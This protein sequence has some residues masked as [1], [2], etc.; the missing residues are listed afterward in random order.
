MH[1]QRL[2][3]GGDKRARQELEAGPELPQELEHL[4]RLYH[5]F[6]LGRSSGG[7]GS[8]EMGWVDVVCWMEATDRWLQPH[9]VVGLLRIDREVMNPPDEI[10]EDD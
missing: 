1:K 4:L 5:E 2:A 7:M 10:E 6:A 9:E 3:E 8:G